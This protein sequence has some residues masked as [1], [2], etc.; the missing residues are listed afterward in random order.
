MPT[1]TYLAR[2]ARLHSRFLRLATAELLKPEPDFD[3][4]NLYARLCNTIYQTT[5]SAAPR[6]EPPR[7]TEFSLV[8][9]QNKTKP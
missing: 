1:Q 5:N 2:A 8:S 6:C 9:A 4:F 7:L 3:Q